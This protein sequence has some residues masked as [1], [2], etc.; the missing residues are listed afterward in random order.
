MPYSYPN[1]IPKVAKNWAPSEQ[2]K[3]VSA[4]NAALK[5]GKSEQDAIFAC[6]HAAGKGKKIKVRIKR[7]SSTLINPKLLE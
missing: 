1:N 2:K 7:S 5:E 3:C 4:A 6:I